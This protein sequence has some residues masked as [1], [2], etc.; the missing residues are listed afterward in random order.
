MAMSDE[1][2][3]HEVN[4]I[5]E[6]LQCRLHAAKV[7]LAGKI[8]KMD[9]RTVA[10]LASLVLFARHS[11]HISVLTPDQMRQNARKAADLLFNAIDSWDLWET[12]RDTATIIAAIEK[13]NKP[14]A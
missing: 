13:D 5:T 10:T 7:E 9:A 12:P 14:D 1:E 2:L 4:K 11:S 3:I 6:D 8:G